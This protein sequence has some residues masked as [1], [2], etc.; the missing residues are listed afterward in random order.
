[1]VVEL[2]NLKN[3]IKN[4]ISH[5]TGEG[6]VSRIDEILEIFADYDNPEPISSTQVGA[7]NEEL[8]PPP[9]IYRV[10]ARSGASDGPDGIFKE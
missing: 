1:M 5:Y 2:E 7:G 4:P 8:S 10:N 3:R 6:L 9:A